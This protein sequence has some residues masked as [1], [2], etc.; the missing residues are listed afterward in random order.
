[1]TDDR[2]DERAHGSNS[3]VGSG[4]RLVLESGETLVGWG[5]AATSSSA[6]GAALG[7][8]KYQAQG[9]QAQLSKERR[10]AF[11]TSFCASPAPALVATPR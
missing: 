10:S 9:Q 1:M 6:S 7:L 2:Q 11:S 4:L 8:P 3:Q 5:H